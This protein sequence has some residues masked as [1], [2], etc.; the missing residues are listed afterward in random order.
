LVF[1]GVAAGLPSAVFQ[2]LEVT[3]L[4]LLAADA[5]GLRQRTPLLCSGRKRS[6]VLGWVLAIAAGMALAVLLPL[7]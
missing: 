6:A 4:G 3:V 1:G 5:W 2:G 7:Q